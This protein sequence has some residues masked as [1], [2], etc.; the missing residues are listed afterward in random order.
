MPMI[1]LTILPRL[2][3]G[4]EYVNLGEIPEDYR[5]DFQKF[6]VG[7]TFTVLP[8][9]EIRIGGNL[10]KAWLRK[11]YYQGFDSDLSLE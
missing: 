5:N 11:L 7:Q 6:I 9:G 8:D 1:D 10:Y 4:R 2:I 3:Q